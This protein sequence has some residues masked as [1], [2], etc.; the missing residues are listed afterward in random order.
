[1]NRF[2]SVGA[3]A[4]A[5]LATPIVMAQQNPPPGWNISWGLQAVP[6]SPALSVLLAL[7][8]GGATYWFLRKRG[9]GQLLMGLLAVGAASAMLLPANTRAISF[10]LEISS[11]TGS[12]FVQC[13]GNSLYIRSS[14]PA[15]VTLASVTPNFSS[16]SVTNSISNE[17]RSGLRLAQNEDCQVPCPDV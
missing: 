11:P 12:A 8:L 17:C 9:R 15:G 4:I 7:M 16:N 3:A 2:R 13:T 5:L 14:V 10:D 1:M 6:L